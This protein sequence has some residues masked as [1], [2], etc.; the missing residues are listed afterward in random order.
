MTYDWAATEESFIFKFSTVTLLKSYMKKG[1]MHEQR[2]FIWFPSFYS[3][4]YVYLE[5]ILDCFACN[6]LQ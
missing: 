1:H 6:L 2:A 4:N 5:H 3:W